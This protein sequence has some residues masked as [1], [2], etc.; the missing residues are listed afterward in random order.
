M[1]S[2]DDT[3]VPYEFGVRLFEGANEPKR[4][5]ELFGGHNDAFLVSGDVYTDAWAEW[6]DFLAPDESVDVLHKVS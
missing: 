6:L 3:L 1:H 4:F 5:V 2:R